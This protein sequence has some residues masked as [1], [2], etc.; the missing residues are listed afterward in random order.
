MPSPRSG[1]PPVGKKMELSEEDIEELRMI[2]SFGAAELRRI[3]G[4]FIE[5]G[6][7]GEGLGPDEGLSEADFLRIPALA[8]NPLAT[9]LLQCFDFSEKGNI[10][11]KR[12]VSGLSVFSHHGDKRQKLQAAFKIQDMNGDGKICEQ[13][14]FEYLELVCDFGDQDEQVARERLRA[15]AQRTLQES[16][17]A[18]ELDSLSFDDF[19]KV[20]AP[21]DFASKLVINI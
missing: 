14:L 8:P 11:F 15:M 12:F 5:F 16:S 9:R 10:G 4:K 7:S 18:A 3:W 21:T 17:S 19:V 1:S 20:V 6:G 13:D 2:S